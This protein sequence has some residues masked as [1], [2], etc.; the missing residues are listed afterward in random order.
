MSHYFLLKSIIKI[1][2]SILSLL[3]KCHSNQAHF[4]VNFYPEDWL[5]FVSMD[6]QD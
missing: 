4:W 1:K 6:I 2:I 5:K 3:S